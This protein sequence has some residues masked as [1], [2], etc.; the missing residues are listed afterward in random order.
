VT[1]RVLVVDDEPIARRRLK[2]ILREEPDV[3]VVGECE[4]GEGALEAARRL[5]PDLLFL[6]VQMPGLDGFEVVEALGPGSRPAVI[7]VTAYDQYAVKAFEVHAV[8]YV[9]K[10]FERVRVRAAL[11]RARAL[12][13][14]EGELGRRLRALVADLGASRPLR[15]LMVRAGGR[16]YFV[17]TE[18]IGWV[19][20][21]GHYVTLHAGRE[22]HLVRETLAGLEARLDPQ[23]FARIHRSTIVSLEHVR[24]LQPSFHGEYVVV[25]RDG[26][27]LQ[28]SRTYA[29]RLQRALGG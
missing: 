12:A 3:E 10:P 6:D 24:E 23:R 11:D 28:C 27:R 22:S 15:R 20:A 26:T 16:V 1:L 5:T 2:A 21:A 29:D 17:R 9:L 7:F 19:E 4:D 8:D 13:T 14:G 18:E 25:L